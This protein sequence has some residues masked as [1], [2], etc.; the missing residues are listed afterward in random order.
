MRG[1]VQ[2]VTIITGSWLVTMAG[3]VVNAWVTTWFW[4]KPVPE[5]TGPDGADTTIT[6]LNTTSNIAAGLVIAAVVWLAAFFALTRARLTPFPAALVAATGPLVASAITLLVSHASGGTEWTLVHGAAAAA[7]GVALGLYVG[8][9]H[10]AG[11][12]HG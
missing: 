6:L 9:V 11:T 1:A 2:V 12:D 10:R 7:A 3:Y 8:V 4:P 5:E